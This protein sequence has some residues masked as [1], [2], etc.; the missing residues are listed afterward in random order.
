MCLIAGTL[1]QSIKS[2][3]TK[4]AKD[5]LKT[6]LYETINLLVQPS[7]NI[8]PK[9][10]LL[11]RLDAIGDYVLFRNFIEILKT[12]KKYRDYSIT[13]LGNIAWKSLSEEL[14]KDYVDRFIW[15]DRIK[16]NRD[17]TYRYKKLQEITSHGYEVVIHP[18]YSREFFYGDFIV[19]LINAKEK[20]GSVGDLSNIQRWQKR[21]SDKYY[22]KLIPAKNEIIFEFYRNKEFFE[23]LLEESIQIEKPQIKLK[24]KKLSFQLPKKYA[25][26]FIGGGAKFRKWS[27]NNFANVAKF[28]K[29]KYGFEIV[30]C[31][32]LKDAEDSLQFA[33]YFGYNFINL[34]GKTNLVDLLYVLSG[35]EIIVSNETSAPH[36]AIACDSDKYV[37]VVSNG[38]HFG[39]F[40]PYP[41]EIAPN[42]HVIYHPEIEKNL[43]KFDK[44]V[45]IYGYSSILNINDIT[46]DMVKEKIEKVLG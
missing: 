42:Y 7:Q 26:L 19:K 23:N 37:F 33:N 29:K 38:N 12:S 1:L 32:G 27:I 3:T 31:G 30:L 9:S 36:L 45:S 18:V 41:K 21:I 4:L 17:L 24:S 46:P 39:R 43:D 10:L 2:K 14:D 35:A 20:I 5:I 6:T 22:T 8:Q 11:I 44:L 34:V 16:F 25:V 40:T 28:L 15:L 13:L